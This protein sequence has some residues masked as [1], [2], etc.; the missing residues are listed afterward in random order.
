MIYNH[1]SGSLV[2]YMQLHNSICNNICNCKVTYPI[3]NKIHLSS[4]PFGVRETGGGTNIRQLP[5][6][7][8]TVCTSVWARLLHQRATTRLQHKPV[9]H[10]KLETSPKIWS[11]HPSQSSR[12]ETDQGKNGAEPVQETSEMWPEQSP[13]DCEEM[14]NMKSILHDTAWSRIKKKG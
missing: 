2:Y 6:T 13:W 9:L 1:N 4:L 11:C 7:E 5:T 10:I 12:T 8:K 3:R 14:G